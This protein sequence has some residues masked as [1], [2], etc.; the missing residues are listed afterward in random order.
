MGSVNWWG[1]ELGKERGGGG[2]RGRGR[3]RRTGMGRGER[4]RLAR[5][6]SVHAPGYI[7]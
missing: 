2:G 5:L 6:P 3:G 4:E 1:K 7:H